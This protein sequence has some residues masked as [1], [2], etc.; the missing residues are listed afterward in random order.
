MDKKIYLNDYNK[1]KKENFLYE[2]LKGEKDSYDKFE[3]KIL[4][5]KKDIKR[6]IKRNS[7]FKR[8]DEYIEGLKRDIDL[9][10]E[11]VNSGKRDNAMQDSEEVPLWGKRGKN[12]IGDIQNYQKK[13]I[14]CM[15]VAEEV[16]GEKGKELGKLAEKMYD[17][18]DCYYGMDVKKYDGETSKIDKGL[19][20]KLFLVALI[21][22][23]LLFLSP[24]LTGNAVGNLSNNASNL[25]GGVL[26]LIGLVGAFFS[27]RGR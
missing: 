24:N 22:G 20:K 1:A 27:V 13:A 18:L 8:Y 9:W 11:L 5:E 12:V 15:E 3:N 4:W 14:A 23:G 25:I 7:K 17:D 2:N 19:L 16:G 26:F 6:M 21:G 10:K